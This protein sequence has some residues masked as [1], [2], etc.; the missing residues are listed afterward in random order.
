M[1]LPTE[2]AGETLER[3]RQTVLSIQP[4]STNPKVLED[5]IVYYTFCCMRT[6]ARVAVCISVSLL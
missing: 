3:S 1:M 6:R 4:R 5:N 2:V